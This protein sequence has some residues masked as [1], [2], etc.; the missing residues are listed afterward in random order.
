M[1]VPLGAATFTRDNS[2]KATS[3]QGIRAHSNACE[4][5]QELHVTEKD[6]TGNG[7]RHE[8]DL[9][10]WRTEEQGNGCEESVRRTS[11]P[12]GECQAGLFRP[13]RQANA[14]GEVLSRRQ[15][16]R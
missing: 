14:A 4:L 8:G 9:G 15:G 3:E 16:C 13:V 1:G 10:A 7:A 2:A 5:L 6:G 12:P 11:M